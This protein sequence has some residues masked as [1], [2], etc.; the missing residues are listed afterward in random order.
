MFVIEIALG[1]NSIYNTDTSSSK[2]RSAKYFSDE[3]FFPETEKSY[4]TQT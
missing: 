4:F 1:Y 2:L 3:D